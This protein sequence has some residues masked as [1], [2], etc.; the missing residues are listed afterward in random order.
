MVSKAS[1]PSPMPR[2]P[3]GRE[4]GERS[5]ER[6]ISI[7]SILRFAYSHSAGRVIHSIYEEHAVQPQRVS[8]SRP[9]LSFRSEDLPAKFAFCTEIA[10]L[11]FGREGKVHSWPF[12]PLG[13]FKDDPRAKVGLGGKGLIA[14]SALSSP[15]LL[16][17]QDW[18]RRYLQGS[19]ANIVCTR[20]GK[21]AS[22]FAKKGEKDPEA[23]N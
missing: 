5:I 11:P 13:L 15:S 17:F 6:T 16:G 23:P 19:K 9:R 4:R 14:F 7:R 1:F 18:K 12:M 2:I 22:Q 20:R 3:I 8:F 10:G 21:I